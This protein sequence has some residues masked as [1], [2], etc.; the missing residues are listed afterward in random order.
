MRHIHPITPGV[1]HRRARQALE[2]SFDWKPRK[3]SVSVEQ[4]LDMLLFMAASVS[5]LYAVVKR[6]FSFSY[7]TAS[8]AVKGNLP[9][10]EHADRLARGFVH[11]LFDV[12][13]FS[14]RDRRRRWMAAIDVHN[15]PYYGKRTPDV[16]GGPKKQGTK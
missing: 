10:R 6:F 13:Q 8:L 4:L 5:S 16:V 9:D 12:A 11:A 14:S 1:V 3:D 2:S 15:V 7:Q